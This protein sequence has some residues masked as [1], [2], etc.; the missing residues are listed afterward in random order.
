MKKIE[1]KFEYFLSILMFLPAL[2]SNKMLDTDFYFLY[3][4][5]QYVLENKFPKTDF[6][7]MHENLS[8]VMQQ[9]L[10]S[11][12]FFLIYDKLGKIPL[13]FFVI[14]IEILTIFILYKTL[15]LICD[16][17]I[18]S[19][20]LTLPSSLVMIMFSTQRPLIF[21]YLIIIIEFY[22]ILKYIKT[23][24]TQYLF[25]LPVL[26]ILQIN[27]HS[28]MWCFMF[29]LALPFLIEFQIFNFSKFYTDKFNKIKLLFALF[30]SFICGLLNPYGLDNML[31]IINSKS[32]VDLG[33]YEMSA[34]TLYNVSGQIILVIFALLM[35]ILLNVN[36]KVNIR[37]FFLLIGCLILAFYAIKL[38]PFLIFATTLFLTELLKEI[39]IEK[40]LS[41]IFGYYKI[42]IPIITIVCLFFA[43]FTFKNC[44]NEEKSDLEDVT[45]F[46]IKN[47]D[48]KNETVYCGF[49]EGAYLEFNEFKPYIDARMEIFLKKKNKKKDYI[50][51]YYSLQHTNYDILYFLENYKFK[52]V[53]A[54]NSDSLYNA[55]QKDD[56]YILIYQNDTY[57]VFKRKEMIID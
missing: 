17:K 13:I 51:E 39:D 27:L 38:V 55:N 23:N 4:H 30:V 41:S 34:P 37:Y 20:I 6:L 50:E 5:G 31:Y 40:I 56:N 44:F 19:K 53:I 49:N 12:I 1:D 29:I 2:F 10:S 33:I 48:T 45:N 28:S 26:S 57:N 8:F 22:I 3:M 43:I 16:N 47:Y 21:T 52:Y 9:W 54:S 36:S 32:N 25:I 7:S 18:L 46:L 14:F 11:V 24:K 35:L 42:Y 15:N